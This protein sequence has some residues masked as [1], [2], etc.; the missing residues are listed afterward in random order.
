MQ[1]GKLKWFN[2]RKGFGFL[3]NDNG[4][5]VFVHYSQIKKDGFKTL[6]EDDIIEYDEIVTDKG[7]QAQNVTILNQEQK[8][9]IKSDVNPI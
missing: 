2:D 6:K 5:D 9:T 4:E 1:K 3:I 7:L 8:E